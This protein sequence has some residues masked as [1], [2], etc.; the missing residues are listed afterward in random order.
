M[1]VQVNRMFPTVV[2]EA[3]RD[4]S[5]GVGTPSVVIPFPGLV[6]HVTP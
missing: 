6:G 3:T 1:S 4:S 5:L 2:D